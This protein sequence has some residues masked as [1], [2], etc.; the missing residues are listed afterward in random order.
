M[1]Q[2]SSSHFTDK[3]TE[4]ERLGN[5]SEVTQLVGGDPVFKLGGSTA[6][7]INHHLLPSKTVFN[8]SSHCGSAETNLTSIHEVAGLIPGLNQW[9]KDLAVP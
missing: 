1:K 2:A 7:P 5:L 8:G 4:T 3:E 6:S 9:V